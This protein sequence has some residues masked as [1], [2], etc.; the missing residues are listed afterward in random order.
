MG[1]S[2]DHEQLLIKDNPTG[3]FV[4]P[5]DFSPTAFDV[6]A[7]LLPDSGLRPSGFVVVPALLIFMR[8]VVGLWS[9]IEQPGNGPEMNSV[10]NKRTLSL[11]MLQSPLEHS[12]TPM[13]IDPT[14]V[15]LKEALGLKDEDLIWGKITCHSQMLLYLMRLWQATKNLGSEKPR[16]WGWRERRDLNP[17]PPA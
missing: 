13:P 10:D 5:A 15:K 17:R 1:S 7:E 2:F 16:F 9:V 6:A 12:L 4:L 3:K 11:S 14:S 8:L